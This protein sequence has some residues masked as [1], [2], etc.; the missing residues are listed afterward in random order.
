MAVL[1]P[2]RSTCRLCEAQREICPYRAKGRGLTSMPRWR[3]PARA[4]KI[5]KGR[6]SRGSRVCC[7]RS[8]TNTVTH[9]T[10]I[11]RSTST[12]LGRPLRTRQLLQA[13]EAP[14]WGPCSLQTSFKRPPSQRWRNQDSSHDLRNIKARHS[15]ASTSLLRSR[16]AMN[17]NIICSLA[18]SM[19]I[20]C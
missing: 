14:R 4:G 8:R 7:R 18:I 5:K 12:S 15:K 2:E 10:W 9:S 6:R 11:S 17:N 3:R 16:S 19:I 1:A 13:R 20:V